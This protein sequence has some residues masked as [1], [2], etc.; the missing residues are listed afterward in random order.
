MKVS[1]IT[2]V[3]NGEKYIERTLL[4]VFCQDYPNVEYIV[5]DGASTDATM[6]IIERHSAGISMVVSE[7]DSGISDAWNK[8][9]SLATGDVIALLNA[10]DEHYPDAVRNAVAAIEAGADMI[11]GDTEL[12]DDDG[13]VLR[14]N[15]GRFHLWWYSAG[16]GFYHPSVFARKSLYERIGG[17]NLKC[18]YAMDSDWIARAALSGA[19]IRH[20][21]SR[22]RMVDGGVSVT[23]R[24]LAYGE[25]LQA[26]ASNGAGTSL[27][28]KSMIMTGLRGIARRVLQRGHRGNDF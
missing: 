27:V 13:R 25:H 22:T 17:F 19:V 14:F 16:F 9:I 10:G 3:R 15:Q 18:K 20:T 6:K 8:G 7:S 28:Y 2:I 24:F 11:Y 26:L 4:S 5:V 12:V 23:N 1:I 21:A